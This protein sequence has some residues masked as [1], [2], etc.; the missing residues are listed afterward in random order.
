M[1]REQS[2]I[3][4]SIYYGPRSVDS[5]LGA[6]RG[7]AGSTEILRYKF[8]YDELPGGS[9]TD[10]V[11][12]F[13]PAGAVVV[14]CDVNVTTAIT[15]ATDYEVGGIDTAGGNADP[16][17][18]VTTSEAGTSAGVVAGAGAYI[19]AEMQNDTQLTFT[20]TGTATAGEFEVRVEY[21]VL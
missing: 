11:V 14:G 1:G 9:T 15:G 3:G 8:A 6:V 12:P 2:S 19:G 5:D 16:N 13:I 20:F 18:F 17:G 4:S 10:A 7:N 21:Y